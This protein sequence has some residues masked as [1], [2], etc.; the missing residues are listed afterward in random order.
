M[1]KIRLIAAFAGLACASQ[2]MP[3]LAQG[4]GAPAAVAAGAAVPNEASLKLSREI[5]AVAW[6]E[7]QR[8]VMM[9][10]MQDAILAP[11][12]ANLQLPPELNDPGLHKIL[13]DYIDRVPETMAPVMAQHMPGLFEAM[14]HAYARTFSPGELEQILAFAHTPAGGKFFSRSTTLL[15][16]P[17]VAAANG[18]MMRAAQQATMQSLGEMQGKIRDY[19]KAHPEVAAKMKEQAEAKKP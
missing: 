16:D 8:M 18:T 13:Q 5:I 14:A 3:A 11:M 1:R 6:P 17:D 15:Q 2:A 9:R 7:D 10:R 12:K 19:F 4:N